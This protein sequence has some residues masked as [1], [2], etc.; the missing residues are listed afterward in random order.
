MLNELKALFDIADKILEERRANNAEKTRDKVIIA[1]YKLGDNGNQAVEAE[2]LEQ[3]AGLSK[4]EIVQA[5]EMASER[6]WIIDAST[7][8]EEA[9]ALK[10]KAVYYVK[11][12]LGDYD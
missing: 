1:I 4:I 2:R 11:G 3:E 7:F 10:P 8:G 12:L 5:V 9:W 6:D